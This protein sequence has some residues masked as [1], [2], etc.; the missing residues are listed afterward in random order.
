M[1]ANEKVLA[2]L[3]CLFLEDIREIANAARSLKNV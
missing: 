2:R 1:S 3:F